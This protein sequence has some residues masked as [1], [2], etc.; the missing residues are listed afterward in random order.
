MQTLAEIKALLESRGLRPKR[1]LGQNFL[2]DHNLIRKVVDAAGV[3]AGDLVLEVGPGTGTMTEELLAR[4]ASVI[5]CELDDALSDL[6]RERMPTVPGG[7]GFT[8][9]HG[10]CLA[11]KQLV[12]PAIVSALGGR[13]FKLVSNLPYGAATPLMLAM[14]LDFPACSALSVTIQREVADRLTAK[15]G[16]KDYAG[17]AVV[18]Q[19][20]A[21]IE[22]VASAPPECFWPRPEVTSSMVLLT[23]R[24][25]PLAPDL[26]ALSGFCR[27]IFSHRRRQIGSVLTGVCRE[28]DVPLPDWSMI[29]GSA[30]CERI[31]PTLRAE[32]LELGQIVQ[33]Q[34]ALGYSPEVLARMVATTRGE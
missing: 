4:G 33:L 16:S 12:A 7:A 3:Q 22:R 10:D 14:L 28:I 19:A 25:T 17:L 11:G 6:L 34:R 30:G 31:E 1:S 9:I 29:A 21:Q 26:R 20:S 32:Q 27:V 18:A 8:L 5:A 23:R 15:P 2:V 24:T 13:A